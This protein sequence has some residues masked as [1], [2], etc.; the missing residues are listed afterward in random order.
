MNSQH[1]NLNWSDN[2][3][4]LYLYIFAVGRI[5]S[6]ILVKIY[7][8][9]LDEEWSVE[10]LNFKQD[11]TCNKYSFLTLERKK[12]TNTEAAATKDM[13]FDEHTN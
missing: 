2:Y 9:D 1:S 6:K 11:H 3:L 7:T 13:E 8:I 12:Q 4:L 10:I 5:E